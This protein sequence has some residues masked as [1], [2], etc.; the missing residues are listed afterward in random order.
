MK[1]SGLKLVFLD[2]SDAFLILLFCILHLPVP[3][4]RLCGLK[5]QFY[6]AEISHE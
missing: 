5:C 2:I 4:S 6:K 3:F 1:L